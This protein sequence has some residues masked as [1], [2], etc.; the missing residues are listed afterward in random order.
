MRNHRGWTVRLIDI[1]ANGL[2]PAPGKPMEMK[3]GMFHLTGDL[4]RFRPNPLYVSEMMGFPIEWLMFPF[5][6][7]AQKNG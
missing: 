7:G 3:R 5:T 4:K 6:R 1:M 2:A